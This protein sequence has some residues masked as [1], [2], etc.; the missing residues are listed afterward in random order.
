M[1]NSST[2]NPDTIETI[3]GP[4]I[5]AKGNLTGTGNIVVEGEFTGN[6]KTDEVFFGGEQSRIKG[7]IIAQNAKIS[8]TVVG[9]LKITDYLELLIGA[10]IQGDIECGAISLEKGVIFNGRCVIT[11]SSKQN[12]SKSKNKGDEE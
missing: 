1:F 3:I 6:I 11:S 12:Q 10:N 7:D 5:K 4:S 2:K 8:G 9:N